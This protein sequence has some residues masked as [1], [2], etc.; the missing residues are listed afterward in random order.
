[1]PRTTSNDFLKSKISVRSKSEESK[2]I[3]ET[4]RE[5]KEIILLFLIQIFL[6]VMS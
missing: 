1:M 4:K 3:I 5:V 6:L 2:E